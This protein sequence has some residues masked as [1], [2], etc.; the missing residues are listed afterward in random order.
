MGQTVWFSGFEQGVYTAVSGLEYQFSINNGPWN[1]VT[2]NG[3]TANIL[4]S[5]YLTDNG[6]VHIIDQVFA[7]VANPVVT[8]PPSTSTSSNPTA[9]DP[10]PLTTVASSTS[11]SDT[12]S[13]PSS[14][15]SCPTGNQ[16]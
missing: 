11:T 10:P 2:L 12:T 13:C 3:V 15:S 7:N 1:T 14:A 6:V 8:T 5:D 9:V 4:R 16:G